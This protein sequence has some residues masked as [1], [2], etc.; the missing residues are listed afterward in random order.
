MTLSG[1]LAVLLAAFSVLA[2]RRTSGKKNAR[3]TLLRKSWQSFRKT[4]AVAE[5]PEAT[6]GVAEALGRLRGGG[7]VDE[8]G[9]QHLVLAVRGVERLEECPLNTC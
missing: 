6:L 4:E 8:V 7:L 9:P 2:V 5:L 3:R 1:S